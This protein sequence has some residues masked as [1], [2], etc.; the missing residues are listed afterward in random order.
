MT[1]PL[2]TTFWHDIW[3]QVAENNTKIYRQVF[4]SMPDSEVRDWKDY[5][6][7]NEYNERF[8]QSQGLGTTKP[9]TSKDAPEKSGPPGSVGTDTSGASSTGPGGRPRSKS[10]LETLAGK[11]RPGSRMSDEQTHT[12]ELKE[13]EKEVN[14][15]DGKRSPPSP[16]S[17]ASSGPTVVPSPVP[18]P[19]DEKEAAKAADEEGIAVADQQPGAGGL[20]GRTTSPMDPS[21]KLALKQ[22][23]ENAINRPRTVTYS[24]NV[25]HAPE[26]TATQTL[27]NGSGGGLNHSASQKRRRRATTKSSARPVMD[28]IM[29]KEEAE[30]LLKMVQGHLVLWPYDWYV[31]GLCLLLLST[32][33]NYFV[34]RLEKEEKGGN[35]LYNIDQ[36]APLEIYD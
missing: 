2:V 30:E 16:G 34:H 6:K 27:T 14:E 36:L 35:W 3:H 28:E 17:A 10:M 32:S 20:L 21:E 22:S 24:D 12:A 29:G 13:K 9:K 5:E 25:N 31:L 26:T 23:E 4:R 33:T 8:M 11:L 1:D 18:G 7:F 15:K 19:L